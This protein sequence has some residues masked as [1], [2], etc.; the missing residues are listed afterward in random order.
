MPAM[1]LIVGPELDPHH[2]QMYPK[3]L[4]HYPIRILS[5]NKDNPLFVGIF[6]AIVARY[7]PVISNGGSPICELM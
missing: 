6:V 5:W 7:K 3:D 1:L 4:C 2:T